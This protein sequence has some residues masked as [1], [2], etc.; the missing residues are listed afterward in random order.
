[1]PLELIHRSLLILGIVLPAFLLAQP[2][3]RGVPAVLLGVAT[4]ANGL[5][6][7]HC[8]TGPQSGPARALDALDFAPFYAP[9]AVGGRRPWM[10]T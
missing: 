9:P 3:H 8:K 4:L 6:I 7:Q 10:T 5:P 2:N 1:M